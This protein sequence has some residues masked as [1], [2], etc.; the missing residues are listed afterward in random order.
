MK[1]KLRAVRPDD[2]ADLSAFNTGMNE[3][4]LKRAISRQV[5]GGDS[6][7]LEVDGKVVSIF[8]AVDDTLADDRCLAVFALFHEENAKL[9]AFRAVRVLESFIHLCKTHGFSVSAMIDDGNTRAQS[10]AR[11]WGGE[12]IGQ[13]RLPNFDDKHYQLWKYT[14]DVRPITQA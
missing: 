2:Y 11:R 7:V 14:N 8:G 10:W 3:V 12:V 9:Y 5:E 4:E 13:A 6:W 1:S